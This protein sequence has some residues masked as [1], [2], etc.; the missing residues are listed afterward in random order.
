M[1]FD[2]FLKFV[3]LSFLKREFHAELLCMGKVSYKIV[4]L[5]TARVR[6]CITFV[7]GILLANICFPFQIEPI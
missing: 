6:K 3:R 2:A 5:S 7:I 1:G 4:N